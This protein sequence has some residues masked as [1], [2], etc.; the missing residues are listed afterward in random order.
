MKPFHFIAAS[1]FAL[2]GCGEIAPELSACDAPEIRQRVVEINNQN[3]REK[4]AE[5]YL[6]AQLFAGI[7]I[8]G[9]SN[10]SE[11]HADPNLR[12]CIAETTLQDGKKGKTGYTIMWN[13][14]EA[15][16]MII[17]LIAPAALMA[18]YG[19][20]QANTTPP[21]ADEAPP[22]AASPDPQTALS[23]AYP[24]LRGEQIS[25]AGFCDRKSMGEENFDRC[26]EP[27][28]AGVHQTRNA[29]IDNFHSR[30]PD[31]ARDTLIQQVKTALENATQ[32]CNRHDDRLNQYL[33][34]MDRSMIVVND[35]N[36]NR[37]QP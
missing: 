12:A 29:A 37:F 35:L 9:V 19:K 23:G 1:A 13:N 6:V 28:I 26:M 11:L 33:C 4:S 34:A 15:G 27:I 36:A 2:T 31:I 10:A 8:V 18:Q 14:R 30:H 16:E 7:R 24:R 17:E 20:P 3:L 5:N 22:A 21:P 25:D 32:E